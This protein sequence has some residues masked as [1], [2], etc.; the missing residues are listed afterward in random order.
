MERKELFYDTVRVLQRAY[1]EGTLYHGH[2]C[3]CA[4][5]NLIADKLKIRDRLKNPEYLKKKLAYCRDAYFVL[6]V[7]W[8]NVI[9][10]EGVTV[11]CYSNATKHSVGL[12]DYT[13]AEIIKIEAAFES[14]AADKNQDIDGYKGLCNVLDALMQIHKFDEIIPK[15]DKIFNKKELVLI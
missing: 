13:I 8:Y 1:F 11:T 4:V 15:K 7:A 6:N 2:A 5:G 9:P 12:L 10:Y 14:A 3:A